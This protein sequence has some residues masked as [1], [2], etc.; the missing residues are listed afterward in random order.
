MI[1]CYVCRFGSMKPGRTSMTFAR[2]GATIVS[3]GVPATVCDTCGAATFASEVADELLTAAN[4]AIASGVLFQVRDL[5]RSNGTAD[6]QRENH[7]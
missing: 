6:A 1:K 2:D 3:H 7:S 5:T 4:A